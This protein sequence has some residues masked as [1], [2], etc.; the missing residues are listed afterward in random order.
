MKAHKLIKLLQ[1]LPPET[2]LYLY[3][4]VTREYLPVTCLVPLKMGNV[5]AI[6]AEP[7]DE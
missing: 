4:S 2:N 7:K 3:I 1:E 6:S 5:I